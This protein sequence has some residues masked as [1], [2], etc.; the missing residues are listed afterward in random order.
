MTYVRRASITA[1]ACL[2]LFAMGSSA[3]V[4]YEFTGGASPFDP[5]MGIGTSETLTDPDTLI[6]VTLTTIDIIG[7]DGSRASEGTNHTTNVSG[8][9]GTTL[10]IN[11]ATTPPLATDDFRDFDPGEGWV[12]AFDVDVELVE[13]DLGSQSAGAEMT[14]SSTAFA[15][16]V[17]LDGQ[18]GDRHDLGNTLVTAGTPI[19][20]QMTSL[21][22]AAD[23][24]VRIDDITVASVIPEPGS[25]V[26]A[27][28]GAALLVAR[29]R[30]A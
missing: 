8:S 24:T 27:V 15:D 6:D 14:M 21:N 3:D 22:T 17:L 30:R 13:I 25:L 1:A 4:M 20:I 28:I 16:F 29:R 7:W 2:L 10:G 12:V 19:T 9:T 5:N 18:T 23:I 26:L 11:S